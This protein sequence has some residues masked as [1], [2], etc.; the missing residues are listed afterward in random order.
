MATESR[1]YSGAEIVSICREAALY[2]IEDIDNNE[3][4]NEP[5]M[6]MKHILR[7][8]KSTKRQITPNMLDFYEKFGRGK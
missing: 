6:E 4:E 1:G 5:M 3:T 8:I 7:S 2:A